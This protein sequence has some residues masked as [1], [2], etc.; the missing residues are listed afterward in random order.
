M[1]PTP[2]K[3]ENKAPAAVQEPAPPQAV[4]ESVGKAQAAPV[5]MKAGRT[6][7]RDH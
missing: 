6:V 4:R 5:T 3:K 2:P 7:R 1:A